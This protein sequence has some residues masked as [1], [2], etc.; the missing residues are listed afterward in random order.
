M[1]VIVIET[2]AF[3][4]LTEAV[5][6]RIE[7]GHWARTRSYN[8]VEREWITQDE[9]MKLLPYRSKGTWQALRDQGKVIFSQHGRKILYNR[10][11][12]IKFI[13]K[14]QIRF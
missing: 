13:E 9:A 12:L 4:K 10:D 3:Y 1:E 7:A 6:I 11:S 14:N 8:N 5:V 2:E